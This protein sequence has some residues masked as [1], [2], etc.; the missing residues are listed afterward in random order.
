[1][2]MN[3]MGMAN[4]MFDFMNGRGKQATEQE[5]ERHKNKL[6]NLT[7]KLINIHD[8]DEET[9]IIKEIKDEADC[10]FSLFNIKRNEIKQYLS[11]N[12]NMNNN[13]FNVPM[14]GQ[15]IFNN[16]INNFQMQQQM[17]QQHLMAQQLQAQMMNIFNVYFRKYGEIKD[18]PVVIQ[19]TPDQKVSEI[20]RK[21]RIATLSI[22][23]PLEKFM[24]NGKKLNSELTVAE[25]GITNNSNI[26]I[27]NRI[28]VRFKDSYSNKVTNINCFPDQ[29][30]SD[31]IEIYRNKTGNRAP[32][33]FIFNAKNV[34]TTLTLGEAGIVFGSEIIVD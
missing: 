34:N 8:I 30:V 27:V 24:F 1:M 13:N 19:C 28:S 32:Q 9:S 23:N 4:P 25:A 21:Y 18:N 33:K 12:N 14:F 2:N 16:N 29:K 6:N 26:F 17:M 5:I 20:I 31:I 15:N 7:S 10:L 3:N 11:Q 22:D